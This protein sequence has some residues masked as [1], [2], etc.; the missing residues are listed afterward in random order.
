MACKC[1]A[2]LRKV[3]LHLPL[4]LLALDGLLQASGHRRCLGRCV[5]ISFYGP[6][7]SCRRDWALL[8]LRVNRC[9]RSRRTSACGPRGNATA[10]GRGLFTAFILRAGGHC[11]AHTWRCSCM[12]AGRARRCARG[13]RRLHRRCLCASR[14]LPCS[15]LFA[16]VCYSFEESCRPCNAA[17]GARRGADRRIEGAFSAKQAT[18]PRTVSHACAKEALKSS[19]GGA[20]NGL[21]AV[22]RPDGRLRADIHTKQFLKNIR[23]VDHRP[24]ERNLDDDLSQHGPAGMQTACPGADRTLCQDVELE[25]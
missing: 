17:G 13:R 8:A 22:K 14:L 7:K 21:Q 11:G 2:G 5:C 24:A 10:S 20:A 25:H 1:L 6:L 9:R 3:C 23:P 19:F 18:Y 16:S 12:I 4:Q 15:A